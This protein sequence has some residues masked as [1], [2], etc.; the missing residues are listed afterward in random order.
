MNHW[1]LHRRD[2]EFV[3][4]QGRLWHED[5]ASSGVQSCVVRD[6]SV[7]AVVLKSLEQSHTALQINVLAI[8]CLG[9]CLDG[10]RNF[11]VTELSIIRK[12][13]IG[14]SGKYVF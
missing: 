4:S 2:V 14:S 10:T 13:G 6:G 5:K 12:L 3:I 9:P 11:L 8:L 1:P 7:R